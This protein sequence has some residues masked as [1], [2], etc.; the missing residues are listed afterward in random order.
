MTL[1][2]D[3]FSTNISELDPP[4]R[5]LEGRSVPRA[6]RRALR[7]GWNSISL[8]DAAGVVRV[9][10]HGRGQIPR[11]ALGEDAGGDPLARFLDDAGRAVGSVRVTAPGAV[12]LHLETPHGVLSATRN[13]GSFRRV[14]LIDLGD[15]VVLAIQE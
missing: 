1:H 7:N 12:D 11:L 2:D 6:R 5:Q 4:H 8:M 14:K 13:A 9:R 3:D 15:Q 10:I